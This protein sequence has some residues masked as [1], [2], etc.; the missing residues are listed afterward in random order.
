MKG[1]IEANFEIK[2]L[3]GKV[4]AGLIDL[5]IPRLV[6]KI[7]T[8]VTQQELVLKSLSKLKVRDYSYSIRIYGTFKV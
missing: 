6:V 4:L 1:L 2:S 3:E 5:N 8:E 7:S